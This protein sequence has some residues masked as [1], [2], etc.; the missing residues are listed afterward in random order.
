MVFRNKISGNLYIKDVSDEQ[1]K[2]GTFALSFALWDFDKPV[3]LDIPENAELFNPF[4]LLG[5][6]EVDLAE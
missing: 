3:D 1:V 4:M 5:A 2:E 6:P